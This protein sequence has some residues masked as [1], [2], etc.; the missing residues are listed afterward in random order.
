M[1]EKLSLSDGP[2]QSYP[3]EQRDLNNYQSI[4]LDPSQEGSRTELI[5]FK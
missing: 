4:P 1:E 2:L 5:I 3:L